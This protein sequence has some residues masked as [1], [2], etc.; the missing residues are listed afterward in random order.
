MVI[1]ICVCVC[2]FLVNLKVL[3]KTSVSMS[4]KWQIGDHD[5][6]ITFQLCVDTIEN[7]PQMAQQVMLTMADLY[8]NFLL[9]V[10]LVSLYSLLN[11]D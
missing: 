7:K 1:E 2:V 8:I 10:Y 11:D 6:S 5:V 3:F 9:S 4:N